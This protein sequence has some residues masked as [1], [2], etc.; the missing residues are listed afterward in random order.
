[1]RHTRGGIS[2][3]VGHPTLIRKGG[4]IGCYDVSSSGRMLRSG[5]L[6]LLGGMEGILVG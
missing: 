1:M 2:P 3:F 4:S 5:G 6:L